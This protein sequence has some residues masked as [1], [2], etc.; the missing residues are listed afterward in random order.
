MEN[1]IEQIEIPDIENA[2]AMTTNNEIVGKK[3]KTKMKRV[4]KR[5]KPKIIK[6]MKK[7]E[8]KQ[9]PQKKIKLLWYGDSPTANTGF[10]NVSRNVLKR[11]Q[12]TGRFDITVLGIQYYEDPMVDLFKAWDMPYKF[13]AAGNNHDHDMFGR[14]KLLNMIL[15]RHFDIV[16]T[17]QD[18]PN[19]ITKNF[20][21]VNSI[22]SAIEQAKTRFRKDIKWLIYTPVDGQLKQFELESV[23]E[24]DMTAFY[25]KYG[26]ASAMKLFVEEV[27]QE[28]KNPK[29]QKMLMD[30]F[31]S[32]LRF[33]YHGTDTNA[34]FPV[35]RRQVQ[36]FRR[37]YFKIR[38]DEFLIINVNRNQP[39][40]DLARTIEAYAKAKT[41]IPALRLYLHCRET[42]AGGQL[43]E[44]IKAY[45]NPPGII[46]PEKLD[47]IKG[48][49]ETT[50]N[51]IY[52][53][54]DLYIT[55]TLGEGWGLPVTEAMACKVPVIMP[56]HSSL[57]EI[58]DEGR[59]IFC[60]S[61]GTT[62]C[63][64]DYYRLRPIVNTD[65]MASKIELIY[66]SYN[67]KQ[68]VELVERAYHFAKELT[69]DAVCEEWKKMIFDLIESKHV[70]A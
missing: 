11:L 13:I 69:W 38:D 56:A 23:K 33:I 4:W 57:L 17:F 67:T 66:N 30:E 18:L 34:Y 47:V 52:N 26:Y 59:A 60:T 36:E 12:E 28:T 24:A 62:I 8:A 58:G 25:T 46:I 29:I 14:K 22:R 20:G 9:I 3:L 64:E 65:D 39:R 42:D 37:T 70:V 68:M 1:E 15:E 10:G 48:V 51:S 21:C 35:D 6:E 44:I 16:I 19:L 49:D 31:N 55:T 43:K 2:V 5:A 54:A 40:K 53:S 27:T 41:K 63:H 45:G 7:E 32:K 61:A 50:M